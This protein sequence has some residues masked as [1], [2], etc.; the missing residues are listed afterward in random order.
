MADAEFTIVTDAVAELGDDVGGLARQYATN[1]EAVTNLV[2]DL[3]SLWEGPTYDA[4]KAD[5]DSKLGALED[6]DK[7]LR[8]MGQEITSTAEAAE[9]MI[10]DIEN[11]M[12]G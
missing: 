8:E 5:Y 9:V 6:L 4:F 1:I 7:V 11:E 10:T 3:A 12:R 2:N